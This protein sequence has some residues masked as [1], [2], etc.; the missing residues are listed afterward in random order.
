METFSRMLDMD[1]YVARYSK[2]QY[3][4]HID[5]KPHHFTFISLDRLGTEIDFLTR[6][7]PRDWSMEVK[8]NGEYEFFNLMYSGTGE[9]GEKFTTRYKLEMDEEGRLS[10]KAY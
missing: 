6:S 7:N 1:F 3:L 5:S 2:N 10:L 9:N 4:L 8:S